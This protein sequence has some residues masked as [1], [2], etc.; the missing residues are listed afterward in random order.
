[1]A[2]TT[3]RPNRSSEEVRRDIERTLAQ[4]DATV[5]ALADKISPQ[6]L[7]DQAWERLRGGADEGIGRVVR[8]HPIPVALVGVGLGWLAV[9]QAT[10]G[11]DP[12]NGEDGGRTVRATTLGAEERRE[13]IHE[14]SAPP[15]GAAV[16]AGDADGPGLRERVGEATS[17]AKDR[18]RARAEE[19]KDRARDLKD[20]ASEAVSDAASQMRGRA[21][22]ARDRAG[23]GF[24]ELLEENPLALGA[25][26][27]G[28]G[29]ASG[30]S[31]PT[32]RTEDRVM[33]PMSDALEDEA[34]RVGRETAE[35]A[36]H[37]AKD[38]A[39][40]AA[41]ESDRM[42]DAAAA[43]ARRRAETEGLTSEGIADRARLARERT[44]EQAKEDT[45]RLPKRRRPAENID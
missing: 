13:R 33:G 34:R 35:K 28:V 45:E 11:G 20:R 29:I 9:E 4:M 18:A 25:V 14:R 21:R 31:V 38:A 2:D 3:T 27:F 6:H 5:D 43:A 24:W 19:A 42:V 1:M 8:E 23:R 39:T 41:A 15:E 32:T 36:K 26:A 30:I 10:D 17:S 22:D 16:R 44:V 37:V 40:A 12:T 7:I